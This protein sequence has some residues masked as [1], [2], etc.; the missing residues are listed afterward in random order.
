VT[1]TV[2][3][4]DRRH[5]MFDGKPWLVKRTVYK[6]ERKLGE[7]VTIPSASTSVVCRTESFQ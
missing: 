6:A 5:K 7:C 3:G 2:I 1:L 4:L